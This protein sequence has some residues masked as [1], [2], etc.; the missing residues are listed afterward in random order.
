MLSQR[1]HRSAVGALSRSGVP[2]APWPSVG[3]RN[4]AVRD[5]ALL[6]GGRM[7]PAP[8]DP[9]GPEAEQ[10]RPEEERADERE[11]Q[12]E[13][14]GRR[15][16]R[17]R[18]RPNPDPEGEDQRAEDEVLHHEQNVGRRYVYSPPTPRLVADWTARRSQA[19]TWRSS[20]VAGSSPPRTR[21]EPAPRITRT[22]AGPV[23][24]APKTKRGQRRSSPT[25]PGTTCASPLGRTHRF[26]LLQSFP[27]VAGPAQLA[28]RTELQFPGAPAP[29][30]PGSIGASGP[31]RQTSP[32]VSDRPGAPAPRPSQ[33]GESPC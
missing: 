32:L 13:D 20:G 24:G 5:V 15:V 30:L 29:P 3:P 1:A 18:R 26:R 9:L 17:V 16:K 31:V 33:R 27:P 25:A 19:V 4:S 14:D 8:D 7:L 28:R 23:R 22:S 2:C 12:A 11:H 6:A 10:G 21:E